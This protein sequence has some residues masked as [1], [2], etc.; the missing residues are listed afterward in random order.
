MKQPGR[1]GRAGVLEAAPD[2]IATV[3][4]ARQRH[5]E[6]PQIFREPFPKGE[7]AVLRD[8]LRPEIAEEFG[9]AGFA[10]RRRERRVKKNFLIQSPAE[11]G[12]IPGE[13]AEDHRIL[14]A[15]ALVNGDQPHRLVVALEAKLVFLG[16][17]FG[18]R[19]ALVKPARQFGRAEPPFQRGVMQRLGQMQ[20]V[21]ET[22]LAVG[23]A[24]QAR[25]DVF[26]LQ[27]LAE[28]RHEAALPPPFM[29]GVK[30][31]RPRQ[32]AGFVAAEIVERGA[33]HAHQVG[34]ERGAEQAFAGWL[35][36]R[37]Q[38]AGQLPGLARGEDAFLSV[39]HAG[40]AQHAQ[41][42]LHQPCLIALAHEH[43][44]VARREPVGAEARPA[45]EQARDLGGHESGQVIFGVALVDTDRTRLARREPQMQRRQGPA[46]FREWILVGLTGGAHGLKMDWLED[47]RVLREA[48]DRIDRADKRRF[49]T[50]VLFERVALV[51]SRRRLEVGEDVR[52][53]K[54]V[55]GLLGIADEE[56]EGSC[57]SRR[58]EALI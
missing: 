5:V 49:R 15:L 41:G 38:Y 20:Q 33:V 50:P 28:H 36:E 32:P 6:Q 58:K 25:A 11:R 19:D 48:E 53:A 27:P 57:S 13:R 51:H 14:Q 8:V 23:E 52:A 24:Q 30:P 47:E 44:D 18:A 37:G 45:V 39:Q 22:P 3:A 9:G 2:E 1:S 31:L 16:G 26:L 4:R 35:C 10:A 54:A 40:D 34:G 46:V 17:L 7:R 55:N 42:F 29:P 56:E 21:G 12:G 43:G